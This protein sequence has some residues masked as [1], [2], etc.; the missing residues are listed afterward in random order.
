MYARPLPVK[1]GLLLIGLIGCLVFSMLIEG[2]KG[3]PS[4][5][6]VDKCSPPY[7]ISM[8]TF[9]GFC[10]LVTFILGRDVIL[11]TIEKRILNWSFA[12]DEPHWSW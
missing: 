12:P 10:V 5:F 3:M 1:Q 6:G 4:L 7:W 8:G 2:G 11:L 9:C